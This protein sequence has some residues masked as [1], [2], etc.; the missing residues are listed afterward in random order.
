MLF[1]ELQVK[2]EKSQRGIGQGLSRNTGETNMRRIGVS[3]RFQG[4][5]GE[6]YRCA[7][8]RKLAGG[9]L[10]SRLSCR[11]LQGSSDMGRF[12]C[13]VDYVDPEGQLKAV[14]AFI[15]DSPARTITGNPLYC[16]DKLH[17]KILSDVHEKSSQWILRPS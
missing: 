1:I 13:G 9:E 17:E 4:G 16:P 3:S 10:C 6:V 12:I 7:E 2:T 14:I 8:R 11:L 15:G 5:G